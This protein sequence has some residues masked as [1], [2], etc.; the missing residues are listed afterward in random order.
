MRGVVADQL[1]A[2]RILAGEKL[3]FG[4]ARDGVA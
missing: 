4:V 2:A 3:D 1:Q